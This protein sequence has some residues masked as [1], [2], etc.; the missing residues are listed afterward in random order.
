MFIRSGRALVATVGIMGRTRALARHL[1]IGRSFT[2]DQNS[3]LLVSSL[4]V[5]QQQM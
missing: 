4:D 1:L 5:K 2:T 3:R